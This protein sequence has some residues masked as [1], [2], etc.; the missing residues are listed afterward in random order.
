[1][2][3]TSTRVTGLEETV[4]D[5]ACRA[6][7]SAGPILIP[8]G[9]FEQVGR[10]LKALSDIVVVHRCSGRHGRCWRDERRAQILKSI[11]IIP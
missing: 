6:G 11:R 2:P 4:A 3:V 8:T 10:F 9:Q 5:R 1:M 7:E